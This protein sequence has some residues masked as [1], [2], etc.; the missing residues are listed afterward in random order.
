MQ[1][2]EPI[3]RVVFRR[4]RTEPRSVIAF[5]PDQREH[6]GMIGSYEHIGQHSAAAYPHSGTVPASE[7]DSDV[8]ALKRE[9]ERIGYRLRVVKRVSYRSKP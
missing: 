6:G 3:Q 4:W 1:T 7:T 5:F 9:L 2:E 8:Q